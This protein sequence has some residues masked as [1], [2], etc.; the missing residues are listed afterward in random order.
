VV[1]APPAPSQLTFRVE[2]NYIEVDAVVTDAQGKFIRDLTAQDFEVLEDKRAQKVDVFT[3]VDIPLQ[4]DDKP[5]YRHT[6]VEPDVA[7][8]EKEFDGRVYVLLLDAN[9]VPAID[10]TLVK[11]AARQFIDDFLGANDLASVVLIQTGSRNDSQEFTSSKAALRAAVDKFTGEKIPSRALAVSEDAVRRKDLQAAGIDVLD[12]QDPQAIERAAKARGTL[13]AMVRLSNY[14]AGVRGRRKAVVLFSEG[15]DMDLDDTIGPAPAGGDLGVPREPLNRNTSDE[16]MQGAATHEAIRAMFEAASR[17]N[18][19]IYAVDP[20]GV[21]SEQDTLIQTTGL[22]GQD[23]PIGVGSVTRAVR[24][25]LRRQIGTLRSFSE[26]TGGRALVGTNDFTSGFRRIVEDNSAYYVLGY[27]QTDAKRD[28]KFHEIT[29]R[30]KRP[31]VEIRARRGYYALK[32]TGP[33]PAVDPLVTLLNSPLPVGGLGLRLTA[34]PMKGTPPNDRV[35]LTV[36]I[37]ARDL[38]AAAKSATGSKVELSFIA[39]DSSGKVFG[40]GRKTMDLALRPETRQ[41]VADRG[42]RLVTPLDLPPGHYQL[43]LAAY[44]PAGGQAGSVFGDLDVPDFTKEPLAMSALLLTSAAAGRMPTSL[45]SPELSKL[46][47]GPPTAT[48]EFVLEDTLA[49]FA[50]IYDNDAGR[51]HTVDISVTVRTDDGTQVFV[52]REER[53]SRDLGADRA[54]YPYLARIPLRDLVPG[55]Y[56]LT[57]EAKSRLGGGVIREL[58]FSIK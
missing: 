48:R 6:P 1:Q 57:V 41:S 35:H 5:G 31:G 14:M 38:A 27:H 24:D 10:T 52:T 12:A 47:P 30:V 28:G 45:D 29:V 23:F 43:R 25:E 44:E 16:A 40:S 58:V 53:S 37:A 18:V 51:P 3:L 15:L 19:A 22:P 54:S 8:N 49:V 9:H 26:V 13:D 39:V 17:A 36:E 33:A 7:T 46:L 32:E 55:R 20:R 34:S 11:R 21:A 4:R 50:D 56:V 42:I 2:A